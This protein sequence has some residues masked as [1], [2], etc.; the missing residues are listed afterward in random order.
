MAR[1]K[2]NLGPKARKTKQKAEQR[3]QSNFMDVTSQDEPPSATI[4]QEESDAED[5]PGVDVQVLDNGQ[6]Q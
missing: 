1:K 4:P 2:S 5:L 6:T 3:R